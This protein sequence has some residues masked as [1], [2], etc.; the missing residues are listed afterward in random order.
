MQ[1]VSG[2]IPLGSTN[3]LDQQIRHNVQV[4]PQRNRRWAFAVYQL[5]TELQKWG[6]STLAWFRS[7]R[8]NGTPIDHP[9]HGARASFFPRQLGWRILWMAH[10]QCASNSRR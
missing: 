4:G 9:D 2:S 3:T 7:E 8:E 10:S 1:E 5:S 6:L